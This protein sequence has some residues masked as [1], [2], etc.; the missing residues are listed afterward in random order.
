MLSAGP[1]TT[2]AAALNARLVASSPTLG[3]VVGADCRVAGA[4]VDPWM[5]DA[6]STGTCAAGS[7]ARPVHLALPGRTLLLVAGMPGAGKSTLLAGLPDRPGLVVLD[8]EAQRSALRVAVGLLP[9]TW[10]RPLVHLLH[11]LAVLVAAVSA[12][13]TVVVHLPATGPATRAAIARLAAVTRRSAHLLWLHVDA[14]EARRG[15]H[16]RGRTIRPVSFA[17]H[18]RRAEQ[19]TA[20]LLACPPPGWAGVTVLDRAAARGGL[21]LERAEQ[22]PDRARAAAWVCHECGHAVRVN[23]RPRVRRR[24]AGRRRGGG[25]SAWRRARTCR[26]RSTRGCGG[27]P[28]SP[29][30][31][32]RL[33]AAVARDNGTVDRARCGGCATRTASAS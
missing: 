19:S 3:V 29:D 16:E 13:P 24:R 27:R 9:Y 31:R 2:S 10:Y 23:G 8:S 6:P 25:S 22:V 18:A 12:A 26:G 33:S 15:Q 5:M 32:R 21:R 4:D 20:E 11:R 1:W 17:E 30:R 28:A 14:V 7:T